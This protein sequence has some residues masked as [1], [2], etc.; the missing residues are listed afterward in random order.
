MI[1]VIQKKKM[2]GIAA[3][4]ILITA[5]LSGGCS[6]GVQRAS[7]VSRPEVLAKDGWTEVGNDIFVFTSDF[8]LAN[9]VLVTSGNEAIL[10]DTG[11]NEEDKEKIQRFLAE[12]NLKL[13]NIIV[14]H[15]HSDHSA[16]LKALKTAEAEPITPKNVKDLQIVKLGEKTLRLMLTEGH[17]APKGHLSVE[18]VDS[19]ILIAGDVICNN[20]LPPIAAGGNLEDLL[21]TLRKL[22]ADKFSLIIP[23]HGEIAANE[24]IF[25]RQFEYL[26]NA[27][28]QVEKVIESGVRM[29]DL[30]KIKLEDCITDTAYLYK[31]QLEYWHMRSLEAIYSQLKKK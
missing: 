5:L 10:V 14:T 17:F 29:S 12:R 18:V 6:N 30:R 22:E 26:E 31:E 23:G 19:N 15:M 21:A 1:S 8:Y 16:N 20:I 24:L 11:E 3:A 9:S 27:K 13:K 7:A 28:K 4:A 2:V 25:K